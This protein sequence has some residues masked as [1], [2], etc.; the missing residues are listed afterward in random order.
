ME[1][2][3]IF[4]VNKADRDDS[5][6]LVAAVESTLLLHTY[7][8][9]EWRPPVLKTIATSGDGVSEL[10]AA[11]DAF[12][13]QAKPAEASRRRARS[14][15]WLRERLSRQFV[16][17]LERDVLAAGELEQVVD[18]VAAREVDPYTAAGELL[19]RALGHS[20]THHITNSPGS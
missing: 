7:Q 18:R 4:V 13:A 2:A 1:I 15:R 9:G 6:R 16:E 11:I 17:Y 12:R 5:D 20:P 10:A 8:P 14:G 3:D 19:R